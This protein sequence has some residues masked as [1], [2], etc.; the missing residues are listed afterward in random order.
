[1]K[2]ELNVVVVGAGIGGL[3]TALALSR[4]GHRVTLVERDDTPVPQDAEDAFEWN[5]RGAPQLQHP[6]AFLGLA[7]TILRDRFPDVLDALAGIGVHA[8]PLSIGLRSIMNPA[9][10]DAL[11]AL[12]DD[13]QLLAC[14]R[15]TFEWVMRQRVID[16]A[17]LTLQLGVGVAGVTVD[18]SAD[19]APVVTGVELE[20]GSVLAADLVVAST[21]RRGDVPRWLGV[22]GIDVPETNT[23]TGVVYFSR[24]Y[25]SDHSEDFGFR[26]GMGAGL[27]AGVIGADAGTYSITAVVD[28]NDRE[29]RA[30]LSDSDRFDA[31]MWLLP[32]LAD[33]AAADGKPLNDVHCM[34][35]LVNRHRRYTDAEGNPS[36]IGLIACGDAHT[37]TNPAYGRGMSLALLQ[38]T[39]IAD[40]LVA[41]DDLESV[42]RQY[43]AESTRLVE[44]WY[45]YSVRSDRMRRSLL[46]PI[47]HPASPEDN[48]ESGGFN[49]I[50]MLARCSDNVELIRAAIRVIHLLEPPQTLIDRLPEIE[51]EIAAAPPERRQPP[52]TGRPQPTRDE[53][54]AAVG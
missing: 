5:R 13:L 38:A 12:D 49:L 46:D 6:H 25:Q 21:G 47:S 8:I 30:H 15:T 27:M 23:E 2:G 37:C 28:Q 44:P 29:L 14:R 22:H 31:T 35:G 39:F 20:D 32:E 24:F 34:T 19:G 7:R 50:G 4:A 17:N 33:V 53:L 54:L 40:A 36:V 52:P 41:H 18:S 11:A 3:G 26:A 48:A 43:E 10:F 42:A 1:M 9:T 16:Q 45:H 51:A